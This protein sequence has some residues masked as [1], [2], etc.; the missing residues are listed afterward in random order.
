M[1]QQ[2]IDR[3]PDLKQLRDEGY[4][5]EVKG[6]Y[7]L[8]HHIPYV[9]HSKE[10]NYGILISDLNLG[11]N[12]TVPPQTHVVNFM[13]EYP[14][15]NDGSEISGIRHANL[16]HT[17]LDGIT[18]NYSF[19]NKPMNGYSN[20]YQKVTTY[21]NIISAPAKSLDSKVTEKTFKV[22]VDDSDNA[23]FQYVDT[24][25]S[26]A[27]ITALNEKFKGQK[28]AI[29]GLGGTGAYILDLVAKTPV[30]E[31]HLF[32]GDVFLMHNAFRSPGA[33]GIDEMENQQTKSEFYSKSY[34]KIHRNVFSHPYYVNEL[35][36]DELS[37]M[38]FVFIAIDKDSIKKSIIEHLLEF[39]IPF[40]DVGLG[41]NIV[42]NSLIGTIRLT[43]STIN[44]NNHLFDRISCGNDLEN[45]YATNIQ[46]A[47]LNSLNAVFAVIKWKKICGFYQDL[48]KEHNTSFVLNV[49]QI[50]NDDY[51]A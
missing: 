43:T 28:I 42:D 15:N 10:I 46:I 25:S 13:G 22:I 9:N 35:N 16:N 17:I 11:N 50:V 26:R 33:V 47:D 3:S 44:K 34:S 39:K 1:S 2:L 20:Y 19:S 38:T 41:V 29:I 23:V 12:V 24:N 5:I 37:D 36:I 51:E 30:Q 48:K 8:I 21:A 14:C 18:I 49:N 27:K 4:E 7:L 40:I 45:E 32:D 31:I 6:G